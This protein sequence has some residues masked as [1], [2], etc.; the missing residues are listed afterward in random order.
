MKLKLGTNIQLGKRFLKNYCNM[1]PLFIL[2]ALSL[3][4]VACEKTDFY[5]EVDNY[6]LQL[7]P[8]LDTTADGLYKLKLNSTTNSEQTI[9]RIS[10]SLLNNGKEPYPPQ[11]V[12][13]ESSHNWTLQDTTYIVVRRT[14][15]ALGQ[16][17]VVDT[18]YVTQ[19]KGFNVPTINSAS[20][21]GTDGE[22]NTVI[23]PIDNMIGD[24]MI[25]KC[26]FQN[27]EKTIKIVLQ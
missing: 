9:H 25:V 11:K 18:T 12:N 10:G 20:Y 26:K 16:W 8:R 1:K 24:T 4:I 15:N 14:I 21:S 7:N 19:F 27:L 22:I 5:T 13:W 3:T 6:T 23:A 17:V 2:L